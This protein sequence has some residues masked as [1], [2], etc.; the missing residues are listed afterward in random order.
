M[1]VAISI[2]DIELFLFIK[3]I[4]RVLNNAHKPIKDIHILVDNGMVNVGVQIVATIDMKEL[5]GV[6]AMGLEKL[7]IFIY[8]KKRNSWCYL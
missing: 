7:C 3:V 1:N 8:S 5:V 4:T 2:L 6:T